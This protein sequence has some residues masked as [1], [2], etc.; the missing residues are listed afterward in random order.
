M[1]LS[2]PLCHARSLFRCLRISLKLEIWQVVIFGTIARKLGKEF[3]QI[4]RLFNRNW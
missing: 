2:L 3:G 1:G 4:E